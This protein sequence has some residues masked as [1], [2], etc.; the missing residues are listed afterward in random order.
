MFK[1]IS[2]VVIGMIMLGIST[3]SQ[4]QK[5][6]Y[7]QKVKYEMDVTMD[8]VKNQ[9][10]GTQKLH[11]TN[12]SSDTLFRAFY[13]LYYNAFQPNSMMDVRSRTIAD[14]D[15]RVMDRIQNLSPDEFGILEV[16]KL[17]MNGKPVKF[18]HEETILEV[19]LVEPILPG[20]T[21]VFD[22]EFFGQVPLQ[23]RR[24]GRDNAEGIRYSMSQWYPK[25]AAYDTRGWH[26][27]PYIGREFYG[28]F[29]DFDVKITIDKSYT[30]GGTGYLQNANEIG[31]GYEDEGVKVPSTRG[32]NLTWH[33]KAPSVHDFMWAADPNYTH[34]KVQMEN[35]PMVHLL[36]VKNE[37]TEENWGKLMQYTIDAIEYCSENF[38][39]YPYDQYSVIQGGDGGME[40]PMATLITGHRNLRS[41]VGVTVHE[42]IHSWYY[43]VLG[44]NESSEPWLDEGFTTWGTSVVM[45]AVFEKDPNFVH[46]G[47][48]RSYFRLENAGYEEPLTTHGD[49]YNLNSAYG[50]GTYNKGAVFV[51]QMAYV[52]GKENFDK[53]LLKLW[54]DWQFKHPN[55]HD[56]IRVFEQV[57]GLELDWYYDYFIASTKSIDY[58]VK[59]V[60]AVGN[61][62]KITLERKGMMPMPVDLVVT[63]QDGSQE[64]IYLPLVIQ[65]GSKPEEEGMPKRVKT[66]KWPWTNYSTEVMLERPIADIKSVEIDPSKRM[67]DVNRENNKLEVTT[68][69]QKK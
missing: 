6:R 52:I 9:Y 59:S 24:A 43:G 27:N 4:A 49:H 56:V 45:D 41:L 54:N 10:T 63:Y 5:D 7:Q 40:Y 18:E 68:S 65:R 37:K 28:N 11:Y 60:E 62:S 58:G 12:N 47:S 55:G 8:V 20:Q 33:F 44:F 66:Q 2:F 13:H 50:P 16:K 15:R 34:E 30:L 19:D 61:D 21:V 1:K 48:Y 35:G 3:D 69:I 17:S 36:Y 39:K 64:M 22:M 31:K 38:G 51:E 32:K 14:P 53:A 29:G 57:S 46:E 67:A 23:V 25:M 26:A 42:L